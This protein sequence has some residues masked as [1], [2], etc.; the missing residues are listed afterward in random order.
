MSADR[1]ASKIFGL[2]E[3]DLAHLYAVI[4]SAHC[5]EAPGKLRTLG[6]E[7]EIVHHYRDAIPPVMEPQL[8]RVVR[9]EKKSEFVRWLFGEV[10]GKGWMVLAVSRAQ[11]RT[12]A[13]HL[14]RMLM[15]ETEE[16]EELFFRFYDPDVLRPFVPTCTPEQVTLFYGPILRFV[17]EGEGNQIVSY[18]RG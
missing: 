12:V 10:W 1:V 3:R 15:V 14:C 6:V 13:R 2:A 4:D 18:R 8:P 16:G 7:H 5:P 17:M 11:L 9:C